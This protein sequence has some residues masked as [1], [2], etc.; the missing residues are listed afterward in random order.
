MHSCV[1][2]PRTWLGLGSRAYRGIRPCTLRFP[3]LEDI[4]SPTPALCRLD[5]HYPDPLAGSGSTT[6]SP[7]REDSSSSLSSLFPERL[8]RPLDGARIT[9]F[10]HGFVSF[11]L[12]GRQRVWA[13]DKW[14]PG[15]RP[16]ELVSAKAGEDVIPELSRR[17][18]GVSVR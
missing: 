3:C 14:Q 17:A 4:A 7:G 2:F 13:E 6:A 11:H 12:R 1:S 10:R 16:A 15:P 8:D 18:I 5:Y 9:F